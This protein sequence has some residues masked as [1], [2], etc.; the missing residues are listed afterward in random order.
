MPLRRKLSFALAA[1]ATRGGTADRSS[2]RSPPATCQPIVPLIIGK[3]KSGGSTNKFKEGLLD[4]NNLNFGGID[5][6]NPNF[7]NNFQCFEL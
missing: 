3:N 1:F 5:E 2:L 4:A 7:K 6:S